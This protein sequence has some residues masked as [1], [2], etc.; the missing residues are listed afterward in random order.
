MFKK[1][2]VKS[3]IFVFI[4]NL[5]VVAG[6]KKANAATD[7][8]LSFNQSSVSVT[9]GQTVTLI[10]RINPGTNQVGAV[11]LDVT[12]N[13][14]VLRLDSITRS[15]NF[16]TTLG[17]PTISNSNGTGSIDVGL[18]TDPATYIE[19]TSDVATFVF[20]ALATATNSPVSFA[21]TSNAS[22]LGEYVVSTRTGAQVTITAVV[23]GD[24]TAPSVTAFSI[25]E[26]SSSLTTSITT[27]T[28]SDA[29]G[30]TGYKLTESSSAPLASAS[31][32]SASA[33][34]SYT[35]SS[36]GTKTLYAW[37]KDAAGNVSNS[38]NDSIVVT[39]PAEPTPNPQEPI[40]SPEVVISNGVPAGKL[41][42][43]TNFATLSVITDKNATCKFSADANVAYDQMGI[44]F[45]TTGEVTHYYTVEGLHEGRDYK[46]Y[47]KCRDEEGVANSSDYLI[48]FSIKNKSSKEEVK[49]SKRKI[50]T[51]KSKIS[52]G[53]TLIQSGKRFTKNS[54]VLL[55]FSKNGGG[56]YAPMKVKTSSSGK[57]SV[58]YRVNK[59]AGEYNWYAVDV[60]SGRKSKVKSYTVK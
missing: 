18:L 46:Y 12:F 23:V 42:K 6:Y 34:T 55:Y 51:S 2:L 37:A 47:V 10:A 14:N 41:P 33:P 49:K 43:D 54:E 45:T 58:S 28:A 59:P 8:I 36:E 4:A 11:E 48:S 25:P 26:T 31:G 16:N 32:W 38:L 19:S 40:S 44:T 15:N 27:F 17:G 56:Y 60:A 13:Y 53:E 50:S 52:R 24:T 5:A 1:I 22:A 7:A 57:F 30:V 9:T 3:L 21:G 29:V 20:T 39:L 35:F